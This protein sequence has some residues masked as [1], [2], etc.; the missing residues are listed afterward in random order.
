MKRLAAL[1]LVCCLILCLA[2]AL[3]ADKK[4]YKKMSSGTFSLKSKGGIDFY[5]G[6]PKGY[7]PSKGSPFMLCLHGDGIRDAND[8]K[9]VWSSWVASA[10]SAGFVVCAPKSPGQNWAGGTRALT[11]LIEELEDIYKLNIRQYVAIGHSSG[12]S[13]IYQLVLG[14][15]KRFSAFG[16][17]GGR[18]QV[19]EA[20][21][22]KAG[23]LGA[24]IFHFTGDPIVGVNFA[25]TAA[26]QLKS[27][28]ATVELKEEQMNSHAIE[29]Y[30]AAGSKVIIPWMLEWVR[31]KARILTDPGNDTNLPWGSVL[32]FYDKLK[33]E[34]K[35]GLVFLYSPK[36]KDNKT[37]IWLRWEVF[38]DD[39]FKEAAG[40]FICM[41]VDYANDSYKDAYKDLRV[42]SCAL[43][44]VDGNM[45]VVKKYTK[46][47]DI[48]KLLKDMKKY[49]EKVEKSYK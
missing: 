40:E 48:S 42:K 26:Q 25:K 36:D 33:T 5:L 4:S 14:D 23:N 28:G 45:K 34:K 18:L 16:S 22:K 6:V 15:T 43:L 21:V 27:A 30:L 41:K 49:R 3:H 31:K 44:V 38:P 2:T 1:A 7:N 24:Y 47:L 35:A 20:D 39:D 32:G 19:N 12:A 9:N 46:P 11:G 37:A 10:V 8:N 17:M 13:V 29:H